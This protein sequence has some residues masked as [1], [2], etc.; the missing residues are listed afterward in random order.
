M[1]NHRRTQRHTD[2]FLCFRFRSVFISVHRWFTFFLSF[3][4][5]R[6]RSP[7]RAWV[8]GGND[9]S[10]LCHLGH[11]PTTDGVLERSGP[12]DSSRKRRRG[13]RNASPT[14]RDR[15]VS[16]EATSGRPAPRRITTISPHP[17]AIQSTP[18]FAGLRSNFGC[19]L[20]HHRIHQGEPSTHNKTLRSRLLR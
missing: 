19:E 12:A 16:G 8:G 4:T 6:P 5:G 1:L 20:P 17:W 9:R 18:K 10:G 2:Q 14:H 15:V 3:M 7:G 11:T 13:H